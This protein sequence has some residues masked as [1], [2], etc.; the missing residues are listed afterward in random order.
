LL[1]SK[2]NEQQT[3]HFRATLSGLAEGASSAGPSAWQAK[4]IEASM[5]LE[6]SLQYESE[7]FGQDGHTE[8]P[9]LTLSSTK[10][11]FEPL[12]APPTDGYPAVPIQFGSELFQDCA[13]GSSRCET[14]LD[15]LIERLDGAPFPPVSVTWRATAHAQLGVCTTLNNQARVE[16]EAEAP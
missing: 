6:L 15:A 11:G 13:R 5:P 10:Q 9:R 3:L 4:L 8:M 12:K 2:A 7:P 14:A 1:L 16:L